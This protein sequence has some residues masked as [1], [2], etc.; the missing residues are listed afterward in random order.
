MLL[1]MVR[2]LTN[3]GKETWDSILGKEKTQKKERRFK[4]FLFT[5]NLL[6]TRTK[7]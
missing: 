1:A 2:E 3:T 7:G 5:A 6:T 4:S